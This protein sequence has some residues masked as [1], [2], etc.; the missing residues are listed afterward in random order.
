MG[1]AQALVGR[2]AVASLVG[3][4]VGSGCSAEPVRTEQPLARVLGREDGGMVAA[5]VRRDG[6]R[7]WCGDGRMGIR[8]PTSGGLGRREW[9]G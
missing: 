1:G 3:W 7:M 9:M 2:E 6:V 8:V 4:H 5:G